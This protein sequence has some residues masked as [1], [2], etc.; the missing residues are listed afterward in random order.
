MIIDIYNYFK[1][2]PR[3]N[4]LIGEDYLIVE[5]KCPLEVE[6]YQF[7]TD[8]NLITFVINGKKDWISEGDIHHIEAGDALFIKKGVYT[9]RQYLD[10]EYCVILFFMKDHFIRNFILNNSGLELRKLSNFRSSAQIF[11]IEVT[12]TFSSLVHSIFNYFR[13]NED[14]PRKLVEIK[15]REL[16][17]NIVLNPKNAAL[18]NYFISLKDQA[19]SSLEEIMLKNYQYDLKLEDYAQLTSRSIS[20]FKR[21]FKEHFGT[22]PGKWIMNQRLNRSKSLLLGTDLNISEV[23]FESGFK[24]SSH[25]NEVFKKKFKTT[26]GEFRKKRLIPNS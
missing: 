6:N 24:N 20:S 16:L 23:C 5:Y 18:I 13:S 21:D 2:R 1:D 15:F 17:Y 14:I 3:F 9:T 22:T 11:P 8:S 10:V 4:K 7:Y 26:P 12:E 25:F 19:K